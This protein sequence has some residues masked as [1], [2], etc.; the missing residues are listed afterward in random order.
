MISQMRGMGDY[1]VAYQRS[2]DLHSTVVQSKF[3]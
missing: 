1:Q 3:V 2:Q